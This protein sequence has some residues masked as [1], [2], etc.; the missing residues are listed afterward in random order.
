VSISLSP[1]WIAFVALAAWL[2]CA[3]FRFAS[4]GRHELVLAGLVIATLVAPPD[5]G[6]TAQ[7]G[8]PH[9]LFVLGGCAA[10]LPF[11]ILERIVP[12]S[13]GSADTAWAA[14]LGSV[15][16]FAQAQLAFLLATAAALAY[17]GGRSLVAAVP[18]EVGC[19]FLPFMSGG[20]VVV[21]L[22]AEGRPI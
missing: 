8:L 4:V 16:G 5:I 2:S 14:L 18:L 20:A 7:A 1:S 21:K 10:C 17:L 12:G 15:L 9:L 11:L 13:V 22:I 19:P 6:P 3:D